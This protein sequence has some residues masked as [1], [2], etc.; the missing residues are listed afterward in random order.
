[1]RVPEF[2]W[3]EDGGYVIYQLLKW[4][5]VFVLLSLHDEHGD[6]HLVSRKYL[7]QHR[8]A[9]IGRGQDCIGGQDGFYFFQSGR[10][11]IRPLEVFG[12]SKKAIK[13]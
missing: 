5:F 3:C 2:A 4:E 7:E 12:A 13:R 6:H 10:G 9:D 8:L 1:M 11:R